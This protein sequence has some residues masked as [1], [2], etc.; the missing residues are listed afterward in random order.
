KVSDPNDNIVRLLDLDDDPRG[1]RRRTSGIVS[2]VAHVV[3]VSVLLL[4]PQIFKSKPVDISSQGRPQHQVLTY[5]AEPEI[6]PRPAVKPPVLTKK[7]LATIRAELTVPP[8]PVPELPTPT[9]PAPTPVMPPAPKPLPEAPKVA[10]LRP[11]P[12]GLMPPV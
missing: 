1:E 10:V 12:D 3:V 4:E 9:P 8:K 7:E 11:S 5:L 6:Q 2:M